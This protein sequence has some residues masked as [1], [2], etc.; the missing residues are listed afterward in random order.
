[1][2]INIRAFI[3]KATKMASGNVRLDIYNTNDGL[4]SNG[5]LRQSFVIPAANFTS[6][7]TTVNGGSTDATLSFAYAEDANRNDYLSGYVSVV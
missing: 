7:N 5:N 1:M 3:L 6:I 4:N 2:A